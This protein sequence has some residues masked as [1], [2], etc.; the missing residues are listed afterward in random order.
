[1]DTLKVVPLLHSCFSLVGWVLYIINLKIASAFVIAIGHING[2]VLLAAIEINKQYFSEL[3]VTL[4]GNIDARDNS[5][6]YYGG[7]IVASIVSTSLQLV[8]VIAIL[9]TKY[10][11]YEK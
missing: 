11:L 1:M 5:Y 7:A 2:W 9:L 3:G 4:T 10:F 6:D 8:I